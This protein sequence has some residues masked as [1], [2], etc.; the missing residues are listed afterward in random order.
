LDNDD[1]VSLEGLTNVKS[2]NSGLWI[3]NNYLLNNFDGLE[4]VTS[5][6]GGLDI[7]GNNSLVSIEGLVNATADSL[8]FL[9]IR[10]N[11]NLS[12][13]NIQII[14]D[15]LA[16]PPDIIL[17]Y[18]NWTG[19]DDPPEIA[20]N[21]GIT[22]SCLPFGYYYFQHQA[23]IDNFP[24]DYS[25]CSQLNGNVNINGE[26]ITNLDS[27]AGIDTI[28]GS[29]SICSNDSLSSLYGLH[30]LRTIAGNFYL[31]FYECYG[32]NSLTNLEGLNN[33][34]SVGDNLV[35][36]YNDGLLT[37][38]GLD[39][40][41]EIGGSL[42]VNSNISLKNFYGINHLKSAGTVYIYN[43]PSLLNLNGLQSLVNVF[44]D[45]SVS[46]NPAM[47]SINGI[48]NIDANHITSLDIYHNDALS[49]CDIQSVCDYLADPGGEI[50][51]IDNDTGCNSQ[52]EV[53][54]ACSVGVEEV[55]SRQ[56]LVVSYPNPASDQVTFDIRLVEPAS[57]NLTVYSSMGQLVATILDEPL[58]KGTHLVTWNA[59]NLSPGIYFYRLLTNDYRLTTEGKLVRMR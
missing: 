54:L 23:D 25:N 32:N 48:A 41:T 57:V 29:L 40:L 39:S 10:N 7:V 52:E 44:G 36:M 1:L 51:I 3:E 53:E 58:E 13:C 22:L 45:V 15:Y 56:L 12:E 11:P 20:E 9:G 28:N 37:L 17:I 49:N 42:T 5:I 26:G 2:I 16:A 38:S 46:Y 27:L 55:D 8:N 4:G 24:S 34:Y 59:G 30:N 47:F 18:N 19:C 43:N 6:G 31:G 33:L 50:L 35:I 21:C 14:C